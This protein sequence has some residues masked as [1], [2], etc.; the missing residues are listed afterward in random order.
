MFNQNLINLGNIIDYNF[1]DINKSSIKDLI[2]NYIILSIIWVNMNRILLYLNIILLMMWKYELFI[3]IFKCIDNFCDKYK[4][5][6]MLT[7]LF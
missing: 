2:N 5:N 6:I 1:I 7:N 4:K 3:A